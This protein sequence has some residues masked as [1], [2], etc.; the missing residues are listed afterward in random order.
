MFVDYYAILE[1]EASASA[2]EVKS[3]FKKQALKW[4]PDRNSNIDT[5]KRMQQIN[6]AYLI[7]KDSEA[8]TRYDVEYNIYLKFHQS[9]ES[10]KKY[11]FEDSSYAVNDDILRKWME[12]A[13][14]QAVNLAKQ[15]IEDLKGMVKEGSKAA[16]KEAGSQFLAQ[17][18]ISV[19]VLII[20]SII[21]LC[22]HN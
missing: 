7:L 9:K 18:A 4:H 8:R 6:E 15:T 10:Y 11:D 12:N 16:V 19:L 13:R 1:I 14:Q 22:S 2:E 21:G 20:F 3:A 5:T 17:I